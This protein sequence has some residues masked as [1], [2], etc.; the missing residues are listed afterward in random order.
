MAVKLDWP[1]VKA[2][3][4]LV[5]EVIGRLPHRYLPAATGAELKATE[6]MLKSDGRTRKEL[7]TLRKVLGDLFDQFVLD[8]ALPRHPLRREDATSPNPV[9]PPESGLTVAL[10]PSIAGG[11]AALV[12][13]LGFA[14]H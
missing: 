6:M 5:Q 9:I 4:R 14:L 2:R 3:M 1:T 12:E 7:R 11:V 10:P 13:P 8:N